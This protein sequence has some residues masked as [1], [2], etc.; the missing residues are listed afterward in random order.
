MALNNKNYSVTQI[1]SSLNKQGRLEKRN[2]E[3]VFKH[4]SQERGGK[5]TLKSPN[6]LEEESLKDI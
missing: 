5:K 2:E 3:V 4:Q 6:T 1:L